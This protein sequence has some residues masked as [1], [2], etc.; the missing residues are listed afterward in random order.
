VTPY[1]WCAWDTLFL[2]ELLATTARVASTCPVTGETIRL[3]VGPDGVTRVAPPGAVLSFLRPE[4]RF[5]EK[6]IQSFCHFVLFFA[7]EAAAWTW[8]ATHPGTFVLSIDDGFTLAR[9][10]NGGTFGLAL[11]STP[12][13]AAPASDGRTT[14]NASSAATAGCRCGG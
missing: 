12:P 8:T 1:T 6:V 4:G 13:W 14:A 5:D 3:T 2:P 9:L 10:R 7:S 11:G